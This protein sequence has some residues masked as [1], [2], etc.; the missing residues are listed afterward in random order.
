MRFVLHAC[1]LVVCGLAGLL[2]PNDEAIAGPREA[3]KPWTPETSVNLG[4]YATDFSRPAPWPTPA[5]VP[6]TRLPAAPNGVLFSPDRRYFMTLNYRGDV[7]T[8]SNVATIE[9]Y[10]SEAV[11]QALRGGRRQVDPIRR[12]EMRSNSSSDNE[13]AVRELHWDNDGSAIVFEGFDERNSPSLF[14]YDIATGRRQKL[15]DLTPVPNQRSRYWSSAGVVV[16]R[17]DTQTTSILADSYPAEWLNRGEQPTSGDQVVRALAA[18]CGQG[19]EHTVPIDFVPSQIEPAP[20][21]CL[22]M[23][24]A[25]TPDQD[26]SRRIILLDATSMRM[27][28]VERAA[29]GAVAFAWAPDGS[30]VALTRVRHGSDNGPAIFDVRARTLMSI[31]GMA[32][33]TVIP[34]DGLRWNGPDELVVSPTGRSA[35]VVRR[36]AAGWGAVA[37]TEQANAATMGPGFT[38]TVEQGMNSPPT[39]VARDGSRT[40]ILS[41]PDPA[42]VG[43]RRGDWREITWNENGHPRWAA[44]L[45]PTANA[46]ADGPPPL[47]V[48]VTHYDLFGPRGWFLPDGESKGSAAAAQALAARGFAVLRLDGWSWNADMSDMVARTP[49]EGPSFVDRLDRVIDDLARQRLVDPGRVGLVGFSRA[50]WLTFYAATHP[51]RQP[52]AAYMSLDNR[53]GT[54]GEALISA[55]DGGT[56]EGL[57]NYV[58]DPQT[59]QQHDTLFRAQHVQ[60]PIFF[61]QNHGGRIGPRNGTLVNPAKQQLDEVLGSFT[62]ARRPFDALYFPYGV[63]QLQQPRER[64]VLMNAIIDWMSFWLKGE[65]PADQRLARNWE[66]LQADWTRQQAWEAAGNPVASAPPAAALPAGH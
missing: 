43:V 44:L 37:G 3:L 62:L 48:E 31:D 55:L 50:G 16:R 59:W 52:I 15:T 63:H 30:K 1:G 33:G 65:R 27:S 53:L 25:V 2:G 58:L 22:A 6:G 64:L 23:M 38:A 60:A 41:R 26:D 24:L 21:G 4:Y 66:R 34:A 51:G 47:V 17:T 19:E 39:V 13:T 20:G 61:T 35:L 40:T 14:R 12:L 42:L 57:G 10:S 54:S 7:S 8:D 45:L 46:P 9:V 18:R 28:D 36:T 29:P 56:S 5:R 32:P 11:R 49:S